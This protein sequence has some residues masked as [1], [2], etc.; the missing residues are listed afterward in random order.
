MGMPR[1]SAGS[2][3]VVAVFALMT[4][5]S[6]VAGSAAAYENLGLRPVLDGL[7]DQSL[8]VVL[9][10]RPGNDAL[11]AIAALAAGLI[12]GLA[13]AA[14]IARRRDRLLQVKRKQ[15]CAASDAIVAQG[16]DVV[17]R[18]QNG[19]PTFTPSIRDLVG[20]DIGEMRTIAMADLIHP[21]DLAYVV[22]AYQSLAGAHDCQKASYRIKH[23]SGAEVFVEAVFGRI[24]EAGGEPDYLVVIRDVT[25][26]RRDAQ[27]LDSAERRAKEMEAEANEARRAK[28][29][30]L[31]VMSHEIRTPLN[32]ILGFADLIAQAGELPAS[33]RRNAALIKGGGD[34][35]LKIVGDMIDVSQAQVGELRLEPRAFALP[36][37]IDECVAL[38]E[39]AAV[40]KRLALKVELVDHFP[41]GLMGDDGRIRQILLNLLHNAIKFTP[42]G[43]ITIRVGYDRHAAGPRILFQII[44]TGIGIAI[45]DL[46]CLFQRFRQVDGTMRRVHGGVGLGLAVAKG[47]VEL[48]GGAIGVTSIKDAGSTFWFSLSL[49]SVPLVLAAAEPLAT[50]ASRGLDILLVEDVAIN[51][52]LARAILQAKGHKVDVVGDGADAIMAAENLTYDLILMDIQMPFVD[53]YTAARAIRA[54]PKPAGSVPIIAMTANVLREHVE[55]ARAAGMD[56]FIQKPIE[57]ETLITTID[58]VGSYARNRRGDQRRD[59]Q[60]SAS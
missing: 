46:P 5:L 3:F 51:Q 22:A 12:L 32:A 24:E 54:L 40:A 13:A 34:A 41:A 52:E 47:L 2:V 33:A 18:I 44:D 1:D 30:F 53:G 57:L 7:G 31:A 17:I 9:Q 38:V 10:Q 28:S 15:I 49:A 25:R 27:A 20:Y 29:D 43:G 23:R 8:P 14:L 56:D 45:E 11:L 50:S 35:L 36:L 16:G 26:T 21:D 19:A 48:M 4:A 55:A 59:A 60:V 37:L 6:L 58:R 39:G 42:D